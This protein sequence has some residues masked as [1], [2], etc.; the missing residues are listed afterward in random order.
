[1]RGEE[2]ICLPPKSGSDRQARRLDREGPIRSWILHVI[3]QSLKGRFLTN[4][5]LTSQILLATSG[6]ASGEEQPAELESSIAEQ[7]P[8]ALHE[9]GREEKKSEKVVEV[10]PVCVT[11]TTQ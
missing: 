5:P 9:T 11:S 7:C 10:L 8:L 4:S 3:E 1:M 2:S 6:S